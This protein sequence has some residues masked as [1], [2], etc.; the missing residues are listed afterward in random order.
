[1][2]T[3]KVR[4]LQR[5]TCQEIVPEPTYTQQNSAQKQYDESKESSGFRVS[6]YVYL[7][8][9]EKTFSKSFDL[10]VRTFSFALFKKKLPISLAKISCR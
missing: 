8:N 1:M 2:D 7:D 6:S 10:K 9:K 4:D 3:L 5:Q